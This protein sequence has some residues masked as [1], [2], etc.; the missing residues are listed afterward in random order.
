MLTRAEIG[1]FLADGFVAVRGA[2][3][4]AVT[5]ACRDVIW[6]ELAAQG[7]RRDDPSTWTAPVLRIDCPEGG[8][9]AAAGTVPRLWQSYDQLIGA[10]RWWRRKGVGGT[11]PVR[12]PSPADPGDAG[13]HI[14]SSFC[15]AG[16]WR[17]NV[18]SRERGLLA[19]FLFSDTDADSAPT[20]IRRG[21]HLD[22]PAVLAPAGH[23][24][25]AGHEAAVRAAKC[26]AHRPTVLATGRAGDVFL[27]HPFLVHAA[28]WPHRGCWPRMIAQPAVALFGEYGL[29]P[30]PGVSPAP[31]ERAILDGLAQAGISSARRDESR[32]PESSPDT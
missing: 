27:C 21:S 13:W 32:R 25:L 17:V 19:I 30:Q 10:G 26:S 29:A 14:E 2:I 6:S 9:F 16:Q 7:V 31:V 23:A 5:G 22:V 15:R 11:I 18:G 28:S 12:F 8:P 3:P 4:A 20:R 24:G 1:A